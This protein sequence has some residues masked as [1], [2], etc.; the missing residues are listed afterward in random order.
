MKRFSRPMPAVLLASTAL[1]VAAGGLA[2]AGPK[3]APDPE[4]PDIAGK[5]APWLSAAT[6]EG[7][8]ENG[9]VVTVSLFLKLRNRDELHALIKAQSTPGSASYGAYLTPAEFHARFAPLASDVARVKGTLQGLGF[10]IGE[11]P[12]SGLFVQASAPVATVKKAFGVSQRYFAYR[13]RTLRATTEAPILPASISNVVTFVAG[14]DDGR[15]LVQ[16]DWRRAGREPSAITATTLSRLAANVSPAAAPPVQ[17]ATESPFCSGYFGDHTAALSTTP[18]PYAANQPWLVC[19]YT[20]QQIRQAYGIDK[21]PYDGLFTSVAIVDTYASPTIT[22]DVNR[23]SRTYRLPQLNVLNFRQIV[24][25]GIYDVPASDPCGPQ[26]WYGEETLDVEAVHSVAPRAFITYAG[27]ACTDPNNSALYNLIDKRVADVIT[28]S[29]S[30]NGEDLPADLLSAE[31]QYLEQAA[32]EG[33][34][35]LF[36]SGDDGDLVA[37]NGTASG[38]WDATSPYATAVGGTSL[39]L[40]DATGSKSEWGWG[41]YRAF[42][43]DATVSTDGTSITTSGLP[44]TL[45]F[46]SG[47]GGGPSLLWEQPVWQAAIPS[48]LADTTTLADGSTEKLPF[49]PDRVTPDISMV[50]DP[51]TGFEIGETYT[52]SGNPIFDAPCTPIDKTTEYCLSSIGG[53]SLS[54]PLFAGVLALVNEARL[55]HL[56]KTVGFV[57]PA[58][59]SFRV[60]PPGSTT[61]PIADVQAPSQ[62]TAV[63][64]GYLGDPSEVRLVTMNS[65]LDASGKVVEGSDTSYLTGPGYD[66]VTGLGVPYVPTLIAA[67]TGTK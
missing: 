27:N 19:G 38:T 8:V 51:Y 28:N 20:P 22:Y 10:E 24:P 21:V 15:R 14:L 16:P 36:S 11:V 41:N 33:I 35:V 56:R 23:Y 18:G 67:F 54:S 3:P 31:E 46:Y 63:L 4:K 39:A 49:A 65:S 12:D 64:R 6:P 55:V 66:A 17:D 43:S 32:A 57:N 52:T 45:P 13:G 61:T 40:Y 50:G 47:S 53:T 62:P 37:A 2:H 60:G 58:L 48:G 44:A 30:Y 25:T 42:L 29:Y 34:S 59:Y 26:G 9:K 5:L 7:Q 1:S